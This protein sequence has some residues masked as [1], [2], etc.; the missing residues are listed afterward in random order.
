MS[1]L[2]VGE[3][4][5]EY[6]LKAVKP[7]NLA[8]IEAIDPDDYF[9][10]VNSEDHAGKWRIIFFWPKN[11]TFVCPTEISA[12]G[13]EFPKIEEKGGIIFGA[14]VD[15]EFSTYTW[16]R[17][18]E[19]LLEIPFPLAS[20]MKRELAQE[21]GILNAEGVCDRATFI[22]DPEGTIRYVTVS[23]D[24]VGRSTSEVIRQF[25]ALLSRQKCACN[26]KKGEK[27]ID[28]I[29]ELQG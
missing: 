7:G 2:T 10:E 6:H 25:D 3:K 5:P 11:F 20:D 1:V 8:D 18:H 15:N 26:W 24:S 9:T 23:D 28:V 19:S 14:S 17:S 4:F 13:E 22:V 29:K 12:F 16:R 21:L 27:T